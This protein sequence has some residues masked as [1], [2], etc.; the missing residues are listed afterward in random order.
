VLLE[1]DGEQSGMLPVVAK[2]IPGALDVIAN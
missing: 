1:V 2:I